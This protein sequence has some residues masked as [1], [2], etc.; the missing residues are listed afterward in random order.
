M[1]TRKRATTVK[2]TSSIT[3]EVE[4]ITPEIAERWLENNNPE[5]RPLNRHAIEEI[6]D[7][8]TAGDWALNGQTISFDTNDVLQNGQTRL[9]AI[10]RAGT[11]VEVLVVRG[12][13]PSA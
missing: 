2:P 10:V 1:T 9:S 8:I 11:A 7:Q 5:N 12:V 13:A 3:S 4:L 6:A